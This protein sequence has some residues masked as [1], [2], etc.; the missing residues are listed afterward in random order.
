[1]RSTRIP[2]TVVTGFLGAGKT[3]IIGHV[4]A[5]PG[6]AHIAAIV[7]ELGEIGLDHHLIAAVTEQAVLLNAGC[8]C[9]E[10]RSDLVAA[11]RDLLAQA[12]DGRL[13]C[14]DRIVIETS[15]L[16]VPGPILQALMSDVVLGER[17]RFDGLVT[18]VDALHAMRQLDVHAEAREQLAFADRLLLTKTDLVGD[19]SALRQR[20]R[21]LNPAAPIAVVEDGAATPEQLFHA[22][23]YDGRSGRSDPRRW[24]SAHSYEAAAHSHRH[25]IAA[26][27]LMLEQPLPWDGFARW[28]ELLLALQGENIL[29]IKG[30]INVAGEAKPIAVHAVHHM[31]HRPAQLERWPDED[32]R[33]RLVFITRGM[34]PADLRAS[35][36]GFINTG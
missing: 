29:R 20:I 6:G 22:G 12:A 13:P 19:T 24:L 15:G 32:R 21:A 26:F 33:S 34:A 16:A 30:L 8:L 27:C 25:D 10:L 3:T 35:A 2:V 1:V 11:I 9:C 36:A 5:Q 28:M 7:N 14:F 18:V 4:L 17:C 31:F 23:L